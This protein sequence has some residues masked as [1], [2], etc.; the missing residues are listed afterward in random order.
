MQVNVIK[1]IATV[2]L[3]ICA[4]IALFAGVYGFVW[5]KVSSAA[6]SFA[7]DVAPFAT[8]TYQ[9]IHIDLVEAQVGLK[10]I[11][12][13]PIGS[14]GE[15]GV[16]LAVL[17][18]PSWGFVLDLEEKLSKGELPDAFNVDLKGLNINLNSGYM[19]DWGRIALEAQRDA[20]PG[21]DALACGSLEFIGLPEVRKMGYGTLN[22]DVS[23][24]YH[25]DPLDNELNFD[26]QSRTKQVANMSMS[27]VLKVASETLNMQSIVFAQPQLKHIEARY[28]DR[29]YNKKRNKFC[30]NLNKEPVK[31][32][33]ERYKS[34]LSKRLAYE[35][36]K[37]PDELLNAFDGLNNPGSSLYLRLDVP[38]GFGI[39]S[40]A[41]IQ[42]PSD[43]V[44]ELNPYVE[45]SKKYVALDGLDWSEPD[46]EG[47]RLLRELM[48]KQ[49]PPEL[50][51]GE[52][53]EKVV[54][55]EEKPEVKPTA[56]MYL[57]PKPKKIVEKSFK[58]ITVEK[59]GAHIG[60]PVIL[61]TY[62]GRKVEGRLVAVTDTVVTVEH[63]L[64][65][66][67]GTATYPVAYDKIQSAQLYH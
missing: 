41:Q 14:E 17:K 19:Q 9:D 48:Q 42:T 44:R 58:K 30:A 37:I 6:D 12:F 56:T 15:I 65:S 52:E 4:P 29:G 51:L 32:Y 45:F 23:F 24:Q 46:P 61:Y 35:G 31:S 11:S 8:M 63:R 2:L 39:Q 13:A 66:G 67:R 10:G 27:M 20:G 55:P 3:V 53:I 36:W 26:L 5:W 49:E 47:E 25:F 1:K 16:Q 57:R 33:R 21:Y 40:M 34:L 64:V 38:K 43:L 18:A 28:F 22:S 50:V 54:K 60:K 7:K 62:F 59:L